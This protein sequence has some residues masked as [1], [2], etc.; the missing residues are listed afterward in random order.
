MDQKHLTLIK[1]LLEMGTYVY[2]KET[3]LEKVLNTTEIEIIPEQD[4][5]YFGKILDVLGIPAENSRLTTPDGMPD[6]E[7]PDFY[8]RDWAYDLLY[9]Y[10][11]GKMSLDEI[12]NE[13]TT[14]ADRVNAVA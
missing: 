14:E 11:T 12:I 7:H 2:E 13:L 1:T 6:W 4:F 5:D 8:C 3:E 9:D 10:L